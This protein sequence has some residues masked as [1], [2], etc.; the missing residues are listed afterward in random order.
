MIISDIVYKKIISS[1]M[2][3][4]ILLPN[5]KHYYRGDS[6]V[7]LK[8]FSIHNYIFKIF[9][10]TI[11]F[12]WL[13]IFYARR[14]FTQFHNTQILAKLVTNNNNVWYNQCRTG[15]K[16]LSPR[17][18]NK[19]PQQANILISPEKKTCFLTQPN[20]HE[21]NTFFFQY[22]YHLV[23]LSYSQKYVLN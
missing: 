13:F 7:I 16:R 23:C 10:L 8:I 11:N 20:F 19:G 12:Y 6:R 18:G 14:L 2:F 1:S 17:F 22:D 21:H 5:S 4:V 9:R 3:F 15:L